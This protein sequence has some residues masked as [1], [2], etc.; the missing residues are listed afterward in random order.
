MNIKMLRAAVAGLVLSVSGF[1]NAGLINFD[2]TGPGASDVDSATTTTVS[3][4]VL[5]DLLIDDL[6]VYVE[7]SGGWTGNNDL[8]LS[9][10]GTQVQ[11]FS[12]PGTDGDAAGDMDSLFDDE[13]L[14]LPIAPNKTG[15]F[16][17]ID[18]LSSFDGL[19]L[20]GMWTLSITDS[21]QFPDEGDVLVTWAI[22]GTA[23]PVPEPSTLAIF[24]LGIMGLASRRFKKQ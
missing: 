13:A 5:D 18:L 10:L 21:S 16:Q 2:Y 12:S 4:T 15:T 19:S 23:V 8:W 24:A 9:H 20:A 11:L 14:N 22:R 6:N 1:A 7:L 3:F 17:A